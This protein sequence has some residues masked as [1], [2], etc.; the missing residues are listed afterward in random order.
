MW[1]PNVL[2]IFTSAAELALSDEELKLVGYC[3]CK[4]QLFICHELQMFSLILPLVRMD[5]LLSK[6]LWTLNITET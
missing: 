3:N 5:E 1:F 6:R 2:F 4:L